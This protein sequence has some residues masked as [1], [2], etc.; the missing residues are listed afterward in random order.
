MFPLAA[1]VFGYEPALDAARR[2]RAAAEPAAVAALRFLTAYDLRRL[3]SADELDTVAPTVLG[4]LVLRLDGDHWRVRS[5]LEDEIA[6]REALAGADLDMV[7]ADQAAHDAARRFGV[8][9]RVLDTTVAAQP[10]DDGS[11]G[12]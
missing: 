6:A 11:R 1:L 4:K 3:G 8:A 10:E 9:T 5:V 7:D 2:V 12:S